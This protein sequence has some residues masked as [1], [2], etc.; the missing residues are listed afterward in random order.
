MEKVASHRLRAVRLMKR[1]R[2]SGATGSRGSYGE[3]RKTA[4]SAATLLA[5]RR[6][7]AGRRA[8]ALP[9]R[10][11]Q[12]AAKPSGGP[13]PRPF[14]R[15]RPRAR[16]FAGLSLP[17]ARRPTRGGRNERASK[18]RADRGRVRSRPAAPPGTTHCRACAIL[19]P[20][21]ARSASGTPSPV[22]RAAPTNGQRKSPSARFPARAHAARRQRATRRTTPSPPTPAERDTE[23][24]RSWLHLMRAD[25]G[26]LEIR[27]LA[28]RIPS[29]QGK[30]VGGAVPIMERNERAAGSDV[31]DAR[32]KPQFAAPR[33]HLDQI[34][35]KD[36]QP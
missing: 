14:R 21:Q 4:F 25:R 10:R 3:E 23:R 12:F 13:S 15:S 5:R 24:A 2:S 11:S 30:V 27:L 26:V 7:R 8:P 22:W 1:V 20:C 6:A 32:R 29:R 34:A 17:G 33:F 28:H 19:C 35:V 18:G 36:P 9:L 31:P 16:G